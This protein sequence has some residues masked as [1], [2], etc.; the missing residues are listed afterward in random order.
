[1]S[2]SV[3]GQYARAI[4]TI[5]SMRQ[6][7]AVL[8][9]QLKALEQNHPNSPGLALLRIEVLEQ[10]EAL[11]IALEAL[12][13]EREALRHAAAV[14]GPRPIPDGSAWCETCDSV[15]HDGRE[16]FANFPDHR[17]VT[18]RVVK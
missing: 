6:M 7:K 15:V 13:R 12:G 16:H 4:R 11:T 5:D 10:Q 9:E 17:R 18:P 8:T 2:E 3:L 14:R 1:M